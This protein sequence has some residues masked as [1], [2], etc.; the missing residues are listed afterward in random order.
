MAK[1][2]TDIREYQRTLTLIFLKAAKNVLGDAR[3]RVQNPQNK[4]IFADV[5]GMDELTTNQ[6]NTI[7][8]LMEEYIKR[9]M[10]IEMVMYE[11]EELKEKLTS[12]GYTEKVR[13]MDR[14]KGIGKVPVFQLGDY[15][16]FFY[17][18]MAPSTGSVKLFDLK[19]YK[20]GVLI[21]FPDPDDMTR[22]PEYRDDEKLYDAFLE[23]EQWNDLLGISYLADLND[24]ILSGNVR[25]MILLSEALHEK[26]IAEIAD[27]VKKSGRKIVLIAGPS[28]SGKT[29]FAN[30]LCIQLR[31]IG[32]KPLYMGTD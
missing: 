12:L 17:G 22:F 6:V 15:M 23:A 31:V 25:D 19:K 9:D 5:E 16:N 28:S 30:R 3:V 1:E 29:S 21:R 10:P 27:E 7:R 8:G 4:A 14:A 24:K 26:K 2:I 32:M 13:L 20:R 11:R 18:T